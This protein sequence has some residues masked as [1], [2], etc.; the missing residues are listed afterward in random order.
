MGNTIFIKK[1]ILLSSFII[2]LSSS[3]LYG[4][5]NN[6]KAWKSFQ[7]VR[8]KYR[9]GVYDDTRVWGELTKIQDKLDE[10]TQ[11]QQAAF[12]QTQAM[13]L[14]SA[15]YPIL[16]AI[17]SAQALRRSDNPLSDD[18][19]RSWQILR[20]VSRAVPIQNLLE[21]VS[22]NVKIGDKIPS[23]FNADWKYIEGNTHF[24]DK[25]YAEALKAYSNLKI[26][27]RYFYPSKFQQAMIYLAQDKPKDAITSL[28]TIV[29]TTT[30]ELSTLKR[31][32]RQKITDDAHMALGRIYYEQRDFGKAVTHYRKISRE[33]GRFYDSLFEQSWALFMAGYPNHA[34]GMLHSVRSPFF[35]ET[36]NPESTML[37]SIIYFWM[38]RYDDSR[39]EL[40]DFIENHETGITALDEYLAR[41][42]TNSESAYTLF[43]N[44]VTGVSSES[45]GMP[46]SLLNS[47]AA[48]DSMM[49]VRDQ[50][51][52][53]LSELQR[54]DAKGVFGD[55]THVATPRRYLE[56]WA[57]SLKTDVGRSF[58][59]ELQEMKREF[60]RLHDQ[61]QFLYVELLMS[62]KD[63]LL[64]K[65]LHKDTKLGQL[66]KKENI[67]GWARQSQ[68]WASDDKLEYWQDELGYH[69]MRLEP[70]C[71][72]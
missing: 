25:R 59:T 63:Q 48:Q 68:V 15:G 69:I 46:R 51:A 67:A 38:C 65:E 27:D 18:M 9:S 43:E 29:S 35:K 13:T 44:T 54:L 3:T 53:V 1:T 55:T 70:L 28:R 39:N 36:F 37:A 58:L 22:E 19:K 66:S 2:A 60:Q 11:S 12:L 10:L 56:Q 49:H 40:A 4:Q 41:K 47:A 50:F 30:Q 21:V 14:K 71:K 17:S 5:S 72:Q 20:E 23:S 45:L 7:D 16:A 26:T 8:Q 32:E 61:A 64:G 6:S 24:K 34:L 57:N 42:T 52:S 62:Q 33:S 31:S